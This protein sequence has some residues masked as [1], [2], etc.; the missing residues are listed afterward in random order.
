MGCRGL[1]AVI[2]LL[3]VAGCDSGG[4]RRVLEPEPEPEDTVMEDEGP[5]FINISGVYKAVL[6][7]GDTV[8]G[9]PKAEECTILHR[10]VKFADDDPD[11]SAEDRYT[12]LQLRGAT[13]GGRHWPDVD[14]CEA[15]IQLEARGVA[16]TRKRR[17]EAWDVG[18]LSP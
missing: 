18:V 4:P 6:I 13:E 11:P 1:V 17:L 16:D 5:H 14:H 9:E 2:A 8:T 10:R 12:V 15:C 3:A 7:N